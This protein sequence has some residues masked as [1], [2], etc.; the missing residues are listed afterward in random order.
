MNI[1]RHILS[2]GK[3]TV[4]ADCQVITGSAED[5]YDHLCS[6]AHVKWVSCFD[7]TTLAVNFDRIASGNDPLQ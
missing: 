3:T 4:C 5:F 6:Y 7:V 2:K 1:L